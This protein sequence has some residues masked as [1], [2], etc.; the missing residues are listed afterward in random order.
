[1]NLETICKY[2]DAIEQKVGIP[3]IWAFVDSTI[4]QIC[5]P[6]TIEQRYWYTG[7]KKYHGFEFQAISTADGLIIS[8]PGPTTAADGDWALWH[9]SDIETILHNLFNDILQDQ[10]PLIYS[11]PAYNGSFGIMCPFVRQPGRQLTFIQQQANATMSSIRVSIEHLFG[12]TLNLWAANGYKYSQKIGHSP[13]AARYLVAVLLTN[14]RTCIDSG[15]QVAYYFNYKPPTLAEYLRTVSER[16][17][18]IPEA[19]I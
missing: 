4:H 15:N 2:A 19:N 13:V 9:Q 18:D 3:N 8:L 10:E 6:S 16:D 14:I 1:M 7:Y 11:D 5:R 12:Y 17:G